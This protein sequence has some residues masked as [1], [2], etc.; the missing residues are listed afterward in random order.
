MNGT[1]TAYLAKFDFRQNTRAK[2]GIN[3][4]QRETIALK[5]AQGK[6]LTYETT[7]EA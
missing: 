2:L 4:V 6:R 7:S 3:D 5:G 1:L